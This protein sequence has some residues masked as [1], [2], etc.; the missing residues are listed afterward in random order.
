MPVPLEHRTQPDTAFFVHVEDTHD[1]S[2]YGSQADNN[3]VRQAEM[4]FP[5]V[6]TW[7]E[8]HHDC[9]CFG[10]NTRKIGALMSV[11][12]TPHRLPLKLSTV[13]PLQSIRYY[14]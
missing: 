10:V 2:T 13:D 6:R 9:T 3:T 8:E 5:G 4:L 11:T 12:E 1:R 14:P 7:V